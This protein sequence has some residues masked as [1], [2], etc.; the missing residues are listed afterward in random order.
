MAPSSG[1]NQHCTQRS[2][3]LMQLW[4]T[5]EPHREQWLFGPGP[6]QWGQV[7]WRS[8]RQLLFLPSR[9]FFFTWRT[10]F[11]AFL[12][13]SLGCGSTK[14]TSGTSAI[15][16]LSKSTTNGGEDW[17]GVFGADDREGADWEAR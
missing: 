13:A 11:G 16:S 15:S 2:S 17:G 4:H 12:V 8:G 10:F 5:R 7:R 1:K 9:H 3:T 6:P 14:K